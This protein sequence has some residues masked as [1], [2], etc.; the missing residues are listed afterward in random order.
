MRA[1]IATCAAL[2]ML[3]AGADARVAAAEAA[4]VAPPA[5]VVERTAAQVIDILRQKDLGRPEKLRRIEDV[6]DAA[7]DFETM[8]RLVLARNW[9]KLSPQQQREFVH[10]F[11]QHLAHTYGDNIDNY[12]N[13]TVEI[14]GEREEARGDRTVQTRIVRRGAEP[15][16]VDYRMR[17]KDGQWRI[18]DVIIERVSLVANFRSQFQEIIA[19]GGPEKLLEELRKKTGASPA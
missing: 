3:G 19:R 8:A 11:R 13:E 2:W 15:V 5:A 12:R 7:V 6:V 1:A 9:R 14:L 18:I 17:R 16:L 10:L 4:A